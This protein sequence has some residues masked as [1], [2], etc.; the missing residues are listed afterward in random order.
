[1]FY[2]VKAPFKIDMLHLGW[3]WLGLR[4][5]ELWKATNGSTWVA[6]QL[7]IGP[8]LIGFDFYYMGQEPRE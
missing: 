2:E 8:V 7:K 5:T 3:R 1:M 6:W 4:R